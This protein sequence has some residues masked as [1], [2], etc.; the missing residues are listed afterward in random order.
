MKRDTILSKIRKLLSLSESSNPNEAALA[1][2]RARDLMDKYDLS[3]QDI[4]YSEI[5]EKSTN[6]H[7]NTMKVPSYVNMLAWMCADLFRCKLLVD[8]NVKSVRRIRKRRNVGQIGHYNAKI[9][10]ARFRF[11]GIDLDAEVCAYTFDVL[12]RKLMKSKSTYMAGEGYTRSD[13]TI[14]RNSYAVGWVKG[15]RGNIEHLIPAEIK[16]DQQGVGGEIIKVNPLVVYVDN[17]TTGMEKPRD[18]L[19]SQR[20]Q[21]EGHKEGSKVQVSKATKEGQRNNQKHLS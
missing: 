6:S 20:F 18:Y 13:L 19:V 14:I 15:V 9:A 21:R 17:L 8:R 16:I 3:D 11:I 7:M 2:R 5:N 12:Y 4:S 1:L 10:E